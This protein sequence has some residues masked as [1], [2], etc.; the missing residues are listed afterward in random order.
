MLSGFVIHL[1]G[2]RLLYI[3]AWVINQALRVQRNLG[4][5]GRM[6]FTR[7]CSYS[8]VIIYNDV[9]YWRCKVHEWGS[10]SCQYAMELACW[11]SYG[12]NRVA[13][14]PQNTQSLKVAHTLKTENFLGGC[15]AFQTLSSK[16]E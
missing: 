9:Q 14:G 3:A 6:P 5:P 11:T 2:G 12:M 13:G 16:H 15:E 1:Q 7:F 4:V 8:I 10:G